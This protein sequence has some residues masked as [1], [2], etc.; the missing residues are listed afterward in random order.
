MAIG[1]LL[2][3]VAWL[4]A[5]EVK[6]LLVGESASREVRSQ[7]RTA[8][9]THP[10]VESIG[11]LLTMHM[12][13]TDIVVNLEVDFEDGLKDTEVEST[14]DDVEEAIRRV[15]PSATLIFVE[16]ESRR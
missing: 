14:I 3:L 16:P 15:A 13:P 6:S 8:V 10:N 5:Y 4:V 2:A 9:L 7:I 11:R 12:G 1:V